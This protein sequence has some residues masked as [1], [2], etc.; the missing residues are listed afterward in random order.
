VT[1]IT[2][3]RK[4]DGRVV[5][6]DAR[7]IA[8][9]IFRAAQSVGGEDRFLSEEL[10]GVVGLYLERTHAGRVPRV[11]DV[12]DAVE[13]VLVETGHGK[14]AKAFALHRRRRAEA[15]G[16][17]TVTGPDAALPLVGS[18]ASDAVARWSKARIA[19]ALVAEARLDPAEADE[20]ARAVEGRV[21]ASGVSRVPSSLVRALVDAELFARGRVATRERQRLVGLPKHD[22]LARL[23]GPGPGG[24]PADPQA[25][26][27]AVGEEVL[28]QVAL[29]DLLPREAAAAHRAGEIHVHDLG[30]PLR[31]S[32]IAPS[33]AEVLRLHLRG[34]GVERDHGA[35]RLGSALSEACHRYGSYAARVLAVEDVNVHLA[36]F[37]ARLD[38]DSL[39]AE[40]AE[41][42]LSAGVRSF[43]RR[44]G[45]LELELVL[46]AE[47]PE[48][49]RRRPVLPPAP[50]GRAYGDYGDEAL[51]AAR[52]FLDAARDLRRAGAGDR[53]P[54]MTL[55]V[56]AEPRDAAA[57]A[58]VHEALA[59]AAES[60]EPRLVLERGA[61]LRGSRWHRMR[62]DEAADPL[63]FDAG[64]VSAAST[65][66][67]DLGGAALRTAAG[68]VDA[69]LAEVD[70]L[71]SLAVAVA[72]SRRDVLRGRGDHPDGVLY[73]LERGPVPLVDV[74]GAVHLVDA[75][76]ADRAARALLPSGDESKRASLRALGVLRLLERAHQEADRHG[77]RVA[78][79]E[80]GS[81]EAATRLS[82]AS[83]ARFP[84]AAGLPGEEGAR[85]DDPV[86][87]TPAFGRRREP[88][89]PKAGGGG[90]WRVRH[91][92][93]S[94]RPPPLE[95]LVAAFQK[96]CADPAVVEHRVEPWPRRVVLSREDRA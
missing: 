94:D 12:Q 19:S 29:E 39:R 15:R 81:P 66:S 67:V 18:D 83:V 38:E 64:D 9:A 92:V 71:A 90:E 69:W 85:R 78:V 10:A 46:A 6:F 3:V 31:L 74:E 62:S 40:A 63:R 50:P 75:V 73:R 87:A 91:R 49:L 8:D 5:P 48:R 33:T 88:W 59:G 65:T 86:G 42:L 2:R 21:L 80:D 58:L 47:V 51:R 89:R 53:L 79:V 11:E 22:L 13:R 54:A 1:R 20:V 23:E 93:G 61:S 55:L 30:A 36:P 43:P 72:A 37:A 45:R 4:R 60:G 76:G 7:R 84:S 57:R 77:L 26:A 82:Q 68:G 14:T 34:E 32:S 24:P 44:E 41:V 25:L 95:T 70:R 96:S 52:A 28:R 27:E 35:R 56:P 17:V 16:A